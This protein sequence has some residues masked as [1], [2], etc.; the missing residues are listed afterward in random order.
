MSNHNGPM[1][2]EMGREVRETEGER[3]DWYMAD[4]LTLLV[5]A[6]IADQ[7]HQR[8]G[9]VPP[10]PAWRGGPITC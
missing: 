7:Q 8:G 5:L 10:R 2:G 9:R 1:L 4:I 3:E 6:W